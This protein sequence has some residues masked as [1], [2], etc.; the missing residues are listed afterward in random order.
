VKHTWQQRFL[1]LAWAT[2]G[3]TAC[4]RTPAEIAL[5]KNRS[6]GQAS[7]VPFQV[8]DERQGGRTGD[9]PMAGAV[10][11]I[12]A[13]L[14][15]DLALLQQGAQKQPT[16][17]KL[18]TAP[19]TTA[20]ITRLNDLREALAR[21]DRPIAERVQ[22][23]QALETA[24]RDSVAAGPAALQRHIAER[25]CLPLSGVTLAALQL[26][27]NHDDLRRS[28]R[29]AH[30]PVI[31]PEVV[32][33]LSKIGDAGAF[34]A[35]WRC[36]FDLAPS[37]RQGTGLASLNSNAVV[38]AQAKLL[39]GP[40]QP[41]AR[42]HALL[43]FLAPLPPNSPIPPV[44][45]SSLADLDVVGRAYAV[46]ILGNACNKEALQQAIDLWGQDPDAEVRHT[47]AVARRS[48]VD[49][50]GSKRQ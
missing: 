5:D 26:K 11:A 15:A 12:T 38:E 9:T 19:E 23:A 50:S 43:H 34:A 46:Q 32:P 14:Q 1:L 16:A 39:A 48:L 33:I 10:T 4:Q 40:L 17:T 3:W 24:V 44:V 13:S 7:P 8:A 27:A 30:I 2:F 49:C 22:V 28:A 35:M 42:N 37:E 36:L 21:T 18:G 29:V 25:L 41:Q 31:P 6:M 45:A 47:V 20:A